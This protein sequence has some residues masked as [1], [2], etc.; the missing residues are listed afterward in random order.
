M[1]QEEA[2]KE[3]YLYISVLI[4]GYNSTHNNFEKNWIVFQQAFLCR[5]CARACQENLPKNPQLPKIS[6][7]LLTA[8]L[9]YSTL[10]TNALKKEIIHS[11]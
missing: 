6:W 8:Y 10:F 7:F 1:Q 2:N 4:R 9:K 3:K 5:S 11:E